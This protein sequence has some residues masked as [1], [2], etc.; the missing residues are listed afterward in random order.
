MNDLSKTEDR[1][2]QR[3]KL[4]KTILIMVLFAAIIGVIAAFDLEKIK[5]L[6]QQA[7]VWGIG[8]SILVY[9]ALGLTFVPSEPITLLIGALFGP[10][11]ALLTATIG[12]TLA[13]IVE[14]F[15][16][17]RIGSITNLKEKKASLP[18]GLNK[19]DIGSPLFLI[20]VRMIPGYGPK[21]VGMFAGVFH[22]PLWR[23]IWTTVIPVFLGSAIF[24]FGGFGLSSLFH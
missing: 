17:H 2:S 20:G 1:K 13:A 10:W 19:L 4:M 15:M 3:Q 7:G 18:F 6:I 14:Y 23:F 16:G 21:I 12:N 5:V 11:V 24:A 8:I 9:G 22:I